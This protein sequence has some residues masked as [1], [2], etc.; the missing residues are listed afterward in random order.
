M[1]SDPDGC[2]VGESDGCNGAKLVSVLQALK[3]NSWHFLPLFRPCARLDRRSTKT[4]VGLK[5]PGWDCPQ[6]RRHITRNAWWDH[7]HVMQPLIQL[8][9]ASR[10]PT[11]P[12]CSNRHWEF[13]K[14]CTNMHYLTQRTGGL[15]QVDS[16]LTIPDGDLARCSEFQRPS[17]YADSELRTTGDHLRRQHR[18]AGLTAA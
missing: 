8:H 15:A 7:R 12:G 9:P 3:R 17:R 16:E 1:L 14:K 13:K 18:V 4:Y 6:K 11:V 10:A 5:V 2:S